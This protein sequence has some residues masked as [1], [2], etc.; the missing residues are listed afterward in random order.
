MNVLPTRRTGRQ[1]AVLAVLPSEPLVWLDPYHSPSTPLDHRL[2]SLLGGGPLPLADLVEHLAEAEVYADH[3]NGIWSLEVG[4]QALPV[5]RAEV[6]QR[7]VAL[8][9]AQIAIETP[10]SLRAAAF[11][12]WQLLL[13]A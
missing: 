1:P 4:A 8:D 9:G 10:P 11:A 12:S 13:C 5:L 2:V 7:L 6:R 3:W